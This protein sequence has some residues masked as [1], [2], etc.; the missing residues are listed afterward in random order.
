MKK[1]K[2]CVL[3]SFLL[4]TFIAIFGSCDRKSD[5]TPKEK[6]SAKI[7][8][9]GEEIVDL[10]NHT[11]GQK[12]G[13]SL[14]EIFVN[15]ISLDCGIFED[16]PPLPEIA[17]RVDSL[18]L[19]SLKKLALNLKGSYPG[20]YILGFGMTYGLTLPLYK[21]KLLYKPV[22]LKKLSA[23]E[24]KTNSEYLVI[25]DTSYYHYTSGKFMR[26]NKSVAKAA[27]QN[28]TLHISFNDGN[29]KQ[30]RSYK[31]L[32]D[33]NGDVKFV[34]YTFQ[35][36]DSILSGHDADSIYIFNI[37]ESYGTQLKHGLLLGSE[38]FPFKELFYQK[39]GNLSHLCPPS[40]NTI[41]LNVK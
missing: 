9:G 37:G 3:V 39:Y 22:F 1:L 18:A 16:L 21:L 30:C 41:T 10:S 34:I 25:K 5:K 27:M 33:I 38:Q 2:T 40:C 17:G 29:P 36:T 28:Y 8:T 32:D 19:D 23:D 6:E 20:K 4:T 14:R 24:V 7:V 15:N 12:E 11:K 31:D 26:V 35:E 13:D